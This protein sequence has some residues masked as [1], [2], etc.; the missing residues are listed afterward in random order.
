MQNKL[1]TCGTSLKSTQILLA[2]FIGCPK[3]FPG[4]LLFPQTF[5]EGAGADCCKW[6]QLPSC[7]EWRKHVCVTVFHFLQEPFPLWA[8]QGEICR[9]R[10]NSGRA[11]S[12]SQK[13]LPRSHFP[14]SHFLGSLPHPLCLEMAPWEGAM[15]SLV[16]Q[17]WGPTCPEPGPYWW[18]PDLGRAAAGKAI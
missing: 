12:H 3:P 8:K 15:A 4:L 7:V 16:A 1:S 10:N 5:G 2:V 11:Q 6:K 14:R 18:W 13:S 17:G 9:Q